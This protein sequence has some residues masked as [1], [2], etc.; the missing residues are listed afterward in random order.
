[1]RILLAQ[2]SQYFPAHGGGEKSNRLLIEA[3][4]GRGHE[5]RVVGRL[6]AMGEQQQREYLA[7]LARRGVQAS[8]AGGVVQYSH[9]GVDVR[10]VAN[11]PLVAEFNRQVA[12]FRPE[13]IVA[14]TD[15]PAQ[16][17]LQSA[18]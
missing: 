16:I 1:M 13:V 6:G 11:T 7:E 3:L 9:S 2:N 8:S 17:M 10:I 14:S 4:A 15:D 12:D 5:C 18:L